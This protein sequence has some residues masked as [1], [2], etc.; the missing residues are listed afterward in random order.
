MGIPLPYILRSLCQTYCRL[1]K[2]WL[3]ESLA[4]SSHFT[5]T[6]VHDLHRYLEATT[7]CT[8]LHN[9]AAAIVIECRHHPGSFWSALCSKNAN[10]IFRSWHCASYKICATFEASWSV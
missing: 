8:F 5:I 10:M 2:A 1:F 3:S 6:G 7:F 9:S 4:Y